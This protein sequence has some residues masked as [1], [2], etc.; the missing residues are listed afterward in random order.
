MT[1]AGY[2]FK[3]ILTDSTLHLP[4]FCGVPN[5]RNSTA[6]N[7]ALAIDTCNYKLYQWTNGNGWK[8]INIDTTSLS[9]RINN[10]ID[11]LKRSNDSVYARKNNQ[12]VFQYKDSTGGGAI[13]TLQQVLNSGNSATQS[14]GAYQLS[15]S[16]N[17]GYVSYLNS[18]GLQSTNGND[19]SYGSYLA[20]NFSLYDGTSQNMIGGVADNG[21]FLDV[22]NVY[23]NKINLTSEQTTNVPYL[24]WFNNQDGITQKLLPQYSL[25]NSDIYMPY[26]NPVDTLATLFDIR[27]NVPT[28][29]QVTDAD[30]Y[31]T[32][33]MV[34][35][36][37]GS[38]FS[39]IA[40]NS[41]GTENG[42]TGTY[43]F[44]Y[45]DGRLSLSNGTRLSSLYNTNV[46][47]IGVD[48]E[49]PNAGSGS[50]T[51]PISV[52]GVSSDVNGNINVS[53]QNGRFGNDTA[54]IV[55]AK[56][57]NDAGVTLTNGKVVAFSTSGTSSDAPSVKLANNKAD[58]TSANTFGFVTGTIAVNDTGWVI[59]LGKIEKLNTSAYANGD[60]IYL[61]SISGQ[62][63]KNKPQAPY[64]LVYLGTVVKA[65]AGNGSIYVKVQNG[66]EM[67]ELHNVKITNSQ[68]NQVIAYSD[69]QQLWKNRNI[70]SIVD[71]VNTVAT[72]SNVAL[73]LN[74]SDTASMLNP[75][76]RKIDTTNKFV[77]TITRTAG[78]D[79]IIFYI[80]STRYAIKDSTGGGAAAAGSTG[81]V[82]FN[83]SGAFAADSSLFWD[84]T[85]KRLG[86]GTTSP[87][88]KLFISDG[89]TINANLIGGATTQ[90]QTANN[91]FNGFRMISSENTGAAN[92]YAG[93]TGLR[94]RGTLTSPT[95]PLA[96]DYI[97]GFVS[98]A[99]D[100]TSAGGGTAAIFFKAEQ[101]VAA[102]VAPQRIT[103]ETSTT[104]NNS[105]TEKMAIKA[106]GNILIG[107]TTDAG[108]KLD[109]N[110][111][112]RLGGNITTS[113]GGSLTL[114]GNTF[115]GNRFAI[116]NVNT[117]NN[118]AST[119]TPLTMAIGNG[120]GAGV[121]G[122]AFDATNSLGLI[123]TA[124]NSSVHTARASMNVTNLTN[125]V[126]AESGD[127]AFSTQTG[128]AALAE[129]MRIFAA[130]NVGI[131]TATNA[132]YKLDVNG[133]ARI[134]SS[135]NM[136]PTNTATGTTGNQT[137]NKPSGT[138]NIA[139]AGTTVTV[140][141][142][143]VTASSI[144]F[145][146][147][148]T[149]DATATIKNV[150]PSA[151]SFTINL[152]AATTAETS[153]GFFV[154]N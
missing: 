148:R 82:Q 14:G 113:S 29:Q 73:K 112:T 59:L 109:V 68:N 57:H 81:Y 75:Y 61:D 142:S 66:Y 140:T 63:T 94:S 122:Y 110:G 60:I 144:V 55:M 74:I 36:D 38:F 135:L 141:N 70:Y 102:G 45:S 50:H 129:R 25:A 97:T 41:V 151:G 86:I 119:N 2:Q 123:L 11:S 88:S 8:V 146:V 39:T 130:G 37:G 34:V 48:F 28:L 87:Q 20:G 125:T 132:G 126:G 91:G 89:S 77:N 58:S 76:L 24:S 3:R 96:N 13:P 107:T 115:S 23:G 147:I 19:G 65:N 18:T 136:N 12:W 149:N 17:A 143:L 21:S 53:T 118:G 1:A 116:G 84:N 101:N 31:T 105:R 85:N 154:I 9:N 145:A 152:N 103:F 117:Y 128:G 56:V 7:G 32:N 35:S 106:N 134:Q 80:G 49:L 150:V 127:L 42:S 16:D 27:S 114:A 6:K 40:S 131:G 137:I 22:S 92:G 54:T 104:D 98:N 124:G 108:Y 83:T 26:A 46:T 15:L 93:F 4:S 79:S 90:L 44:L 33:S 99:Y 120:V 5:L 95:T 100:G 139:A 78:K 138:V 30:N 121:L 69:T 153:I 64:H 10:R 52:N 51:I 47:S 43:A 72:K 133:T 111:T 71:T 67:E 62:Y